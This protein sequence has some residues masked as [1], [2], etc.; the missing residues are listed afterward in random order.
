MK[1]ETRR[2]LEAAT[3]LE[4]PVKISTINVVPFTRTVKEINWNDASDR[5]WLMNH[6]HWAMNNQQIVTLSSHVPQP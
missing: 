2:A 4:S 1:Y 6:L 3:K 5:K